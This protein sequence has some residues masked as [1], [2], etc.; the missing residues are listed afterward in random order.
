[1]EEF[2]PG[3][4]QE[5]VDEWKKQ[6]GELYVTEF[7]DQ[8][9]VWRVLNRAEYKK[10]VNAQGMDVF[11]REEEI[12]RQCVLYPQNYDYSVAKAG[13]ATLLAEQI[14]DK[15]GFVAKSAPQKL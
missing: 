2:L 11:Q 14:M 5:Q 8:T 10:I 4:S 12:C 15:S 7:E 13:V 6:Y 9:F 3:L 1:M